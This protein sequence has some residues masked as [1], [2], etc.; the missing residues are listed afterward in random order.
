VI[1]KKTF[2]YLVERRKSHIFYKLQ[3]R[4]FSA[5]LLLVAVVILLPFPI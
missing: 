1:S 4:T 3:N 2:Y 5:A